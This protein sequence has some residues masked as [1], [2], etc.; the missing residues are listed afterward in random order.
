MK[1]R[2]IYIEDYQDEYIESLAKIKDRS[3]NYI[4]RTIIEDHIQKNE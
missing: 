3:F 2:S 4:L 1:I